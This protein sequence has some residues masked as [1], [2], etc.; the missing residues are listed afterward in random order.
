MAVVPSALGFF[1]DFRRC[2]QVAPRDHHW[3]WV[4][5]WTLWLHA[6]LGSAGISGDGSRRHDD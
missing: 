4:H 3:R 1:A 6:L 5:R 2:N